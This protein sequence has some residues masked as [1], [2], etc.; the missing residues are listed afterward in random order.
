MLKATVTYEYD[1][2]RT[3][4]ILESADAGTISLV[5]EVLLSELWHGAGAARDPVI[6]SLLR[7]EAGQA[8]T[9]L[10]VAGLNV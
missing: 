4:P 7:S 5:S 10:A 8:Q 3:F 2:G 9:V 6:A 1:N